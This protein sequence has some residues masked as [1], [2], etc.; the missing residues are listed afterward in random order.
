MHIQNICLNITLISTKQKYTSRIYKHMVLNLLH[1]QS[2]CNTSEDSTNT[3]IN[4]TRLYESL[5]PSLWCQLRSFRNVPR[6]RSSLLNAKPCHR[7]Y[8]IRLVYHSQILINHFQSQSY[9]DNAYDDF[10]DILMALMV[11][12]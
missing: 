4:C 7:F 8:H 1:I 11:P 5:V 10:L 12:N 6:R 3:T 2:Q 9:N